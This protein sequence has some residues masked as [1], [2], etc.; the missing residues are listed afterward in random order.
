MVAAL[1]VLPVVRWWWPQPA[2]VAPAQP[3]V[4]AGVGGRVLAPDLTNLC[5][6]YLLMMQA[7][8]AALVA[9][10]AALVACF[11]SV[12]ALETKGRDH[13]WFASPVVH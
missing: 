4:V 6:P 3:L 12:L 7:L 5:V 2:K 9:L 10:V 1:M 8:V 13:Y 11:A